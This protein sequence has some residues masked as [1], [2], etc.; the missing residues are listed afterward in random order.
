M[1]EQTEQAA[2]E[3]L[4]G[5][6]LARIDVDRHALGEMSGAQKALL[7]LVSLDESVAT[8]VL[9]H[10]E[11]AHVRLLR[12][13]SES[14]AEAP[15]S[16]ITAVHHEFL[17]KVRAGMPASLKG[18]TAY[19]RR[20]AGNA[21]GEGRA[22]ELWSDRPKSEGAAALARLESEVLGALLADEQPQTTAVVLSQ[23]PAAK[24]GE[25]IEAMDD[26]RR[27]DVM[28]R[29]TK[30]ESVPE[31]VLADIEAT[32]MRHVQTFG[33]IERREIGGKKVAADIVKRL[34]EDMGEAILEAVRVTNPEA[35]EELEK[36]L[37]TFED[38]NKVDKRGMQ[39][40][41]KEVPTDQLVIAL[42]TASDELK[43]KVFGN[44]SSRAA[45]LLHE[46]LELLGPVRLTDVEEAQRAI[47]QTAIELEK[48]G[49]LTI[50][51]EGGGDYV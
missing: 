31:D 29:L 35:A 2:Q 39:Q 5:D 42:K 36:A 47:C 50:A 22:S 48:E 17:E 18:S 24:A 32:F 41:L 30:L 8:R 10:L 26:E 27:N 1:S 38:L 40:L 7:F 33:D 23:L 16:S 20:L 12:D 3:L 45:D 34:P 51:R 49:R 14:M 21:L 4:V 11:D 46:E 43:E 13:S 9:G 44:V 37:F 15:P 25:L 6:G 19:L 28:M